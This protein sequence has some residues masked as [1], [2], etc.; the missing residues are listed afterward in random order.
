MLQRKT[1]ESNTLELLTEI[2]KRPYFH[3]L[4]LVGGT[5]LALQIGHRKSIDLDFFGKLALTQEG[6]FENLNKL[7]V[8]LI[9]K[10][11]NIFSYSVNNVKVDFV[12][13]PYDWID[14]AIIIDDIIMA[15][16]KDIGAM[17]INAI[18]GRGKRKDFYDLYYLLHHFSLPEIFSWFDQKYPD[19]NRMLAYRSI[20]Y[21]ED[22]EAEEDPYL[23]EDISWEKVK[24][25]IKER[26]KVFL[27]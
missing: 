23:F 21:F 11:P 2:M 15:S 6:I 13:Y 9:Y 19:G 27:M 8:S 4:R 7:Q 5:A 10:T 18:T 1:I 20:T 14:Q 26:V 25:F 17:K 22:A 16:Q 12:N 3:N 24:D